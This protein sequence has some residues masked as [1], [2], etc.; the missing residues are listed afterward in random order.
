ME[1]NEIMTHPVNIATFNLENLHDAPDQT[2][3]LETRAAILR[4]QLERLN[5]D[6]ICFQEIHSQQTNG[7][8]RELHALKNLLKGTSYQDFELITTTKLESNEPFSQRNLVIASRFP[9]IAHDQYLH[10]FTP[11]PEYRTITSDP[12]QKEATDVTWERPLLHAQIN[13]SDNITLDVLNVHLKSKNPTTIPGQKVDPYTWKSASGWAEGFFLS[14]LRRVGQ[15]LETRVFI[16]SLFDKNPQ[17]YIIIAGDFNA[18]AHEVPVEAIRGRVENTGNGDLA[19][20]VLIPAEESIPEPS[21]FTLY[22]QGRK[23][24]LDHI[25]ISLSM[26]PFYQVTEIHNENL[27]DETIAF[28]TDEKYPQ[29]DHAA[30]VARFSIPQPSVKD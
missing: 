12:P 7:G 1:Y 3:S 20:R 24:M 19:E 28:A 13:V 4:P 10:T 15:A 17:A 2:P 26:L 9:V 29:S 16:D 18:D 8:P 21:R 22:H 30:V 6:I 25:L 5:A 14:S 27:P 11:P 23:N